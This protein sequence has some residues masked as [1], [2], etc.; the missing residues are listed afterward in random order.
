MLLLYL[1]KDILQYILNS[2]LFYEYEVPILEKIINS[3]FIF[4]IKPHLTF[5]EEIIKLESGKKKKI[6]CCM[7][8]E[9]IKTE[10]WICNSGYEYYKRSESIYSNRK[11]YKNSI[12]YS[13][14]K[15]MHEYNYNSGKLHGDQFAYTREGNLERHI[16]YNNGVSIFG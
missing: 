3:D 8:D 5:H 9:I 10:I 7:D 15:V 2:Y 14:G 4:D 6:Y 13:N 12:F 11:L 16:L 1:H